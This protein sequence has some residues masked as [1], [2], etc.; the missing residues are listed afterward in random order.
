VHLRAE[1]GGKPL[2]LVLTPGQQH[3][4][5]VFEELLTAGEVKRPGR[6]RPRVRPHW[7][8]GDKGYTGRRYRAFCRGRGI[9]YTI[10]RQ[11]KER[12]SGPFNRAT[13]RLR[14]RVERLI[15]RFKQ[16]R[17]LATRYEKLAES[18]RAL[19]VIAAIIFWL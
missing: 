5:T 17:S 3:E 19:W 9:R 4:A 14:N 16:Y 13:Y 12:R 7:V 10:P 11:S 1:G 2:T 6:G 8:V 15:N 18:Y